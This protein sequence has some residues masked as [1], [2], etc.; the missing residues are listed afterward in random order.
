MR[1]SDGVKRYSDE[2][3]KRIFDEI[4]A[5]AEAENMADISRRDNGNII[6]ENKNKEDITMENNAKIRSRKGGVIAAACAVLAVGGG[7]FAATHING[8]PAIA[9]AATGTSVTTDAEDSMTVDYTAEETTEEEDKGVDDIVEIPDNMEMWEL[10]AS[11]E[12][13]QLVKNSGFIG[14]VQIVS[15]NRTNIDGV[16]YADYLCNGKGDENGNCTV[17]KNETGLT[18]DEVHIL[19]PINTES[20]WANEGDKV[21]VFAKVGAKGDEDGVYL[22]LCDDKCMFSWSNEVN[23]YRNLAEPGYVEAVGDLQSY[24][25]VADNYVDGYLE[26]D[27]DEYCK[28][29]LT[30]LTWDHGVSNMINWCYYNGVEIKVFKR[31]EGFTSDPT[32]MSYDSDAYIEVD[33]KEIYEEDP[34]GS[35]TSWYSYQDAEGNLFDGITIEIEDGTRIPSD[36]GFDKYWV[37]GS[38]KLNVHDKG[39]VAEEFEGYDME[40]DSINYL[41]EEGS[42][43][44]TV[45]VRKTDGSVF[46]I[47]ADDNSM[48]L[49]YGDVEAIFDY[50]DAE[51]LDSGLSWVDPEDPSTM[52]THFLFHFDSSNNLFERE[53]SPEFTFEINQINYRDEVTDGLFRFNFVIDSNDLIE[54]KLS[55]SPKNN[56]D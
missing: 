52:K 48:N 51:S 53:S 45:D 26:H 9:P 23:K 32:M 17:F 4:T 15:V 27:V 41:P 28:S 38:F 20:T 18:T 36:S 42:L 21:L 55:L 14:E 43:L 37:E 3:K 2:T 30:D 40:L 7:I 25:I 5:A 12:M 1:F 13:K 46:D 22:E 11:E 29:V 6:I 54:D 44:M 19:E 31:N 34:L 24:D 33:P 10:D 50:L 47:Y 35:A 8:G 56:N 49:I 39:T 16:D